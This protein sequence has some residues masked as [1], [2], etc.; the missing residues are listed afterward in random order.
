MKKYFF[1]SKSDKSKQ[2]ISK[3][4]ANSRLSAAKYFSKVKGLSLKSFLN[5]FKVSK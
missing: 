3:I 2:P 1:Y 5:L 4:E